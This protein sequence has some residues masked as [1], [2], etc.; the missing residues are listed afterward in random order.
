MFDYYTPPSQEVFDDIKQASIKVW[1]SMDD[2]Y[3]YTTDKI[4]RIKDLENVQ[5]NAW[6]MFAMFDIFNQAKLI[7][8]VSPT[9]QE[10]IQEMLG[11]SK[12]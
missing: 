5:D 7:D 12:S 9:T 11:W 3:G 8:L 6:Y 4:K 2:T 10:K 1:Q